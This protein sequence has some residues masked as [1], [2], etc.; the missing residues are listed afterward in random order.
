MI[1][2][3]RDWGRFFILKRNKTSALAQ[4]ANSPYDLK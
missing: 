3:D 1:I 4:N 2:G